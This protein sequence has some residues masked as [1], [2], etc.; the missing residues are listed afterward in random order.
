MPLQIFGNDAGATTPSA[1]V[2]RL[3]DTS[4]G[5]YPTD[6]YSCKSKYPDFS[7]CNNNNSYGACCPE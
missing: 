3:N 4:I 5:I 2:H 6:C 7:Y 1:S